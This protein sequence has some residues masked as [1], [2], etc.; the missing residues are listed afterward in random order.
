MF[1][2][3]I[4]TYN[5][6]D[7]LKNCLESLLNQTYKNFEVIVSDDGSS[8]NTSEIVEAAK[9]R[10]LQVKYIYN[11]NWGGPARPRN[12]GIKNSKYKWICFLDSDDWW[13]PEKLEN[14]V[15]F[16][17][18]NYDFIYHDFKLYVNGVLTKKRLKGRQLKQPV[19]NDLFINDNCII[20]S[21]VCVRKDIIEKAGGFSEDKELI[22]VE[23]YDLWLRCS[24]ITEKFKYI[25]EFL[26]GYDVGNDSITV[27][28]IKLINR[29]DKLFSYYKKFMKPPEIKLAEI[30][31]SYKK[32]VTYQRMSRFD[33]ARKNYLIAAKSP[34]LSI[35]VKAIVR[36]FSLLLKK[37]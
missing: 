1:S 9:R 23:D 4:P 32:A 12:I 14:I 37:L 31:W 33:E 6:A 5:R 18:E 24:R 19:F 8:D 15:P 34:V 2:V 29:F 7:K 27:N 36:F 35:K 17:N 10:G 28:D 3:V 22:V 13:Y 16:C 20:N 11:S 25:P 21:A 26:G 30:N